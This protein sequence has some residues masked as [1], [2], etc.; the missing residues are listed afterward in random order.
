MTP[1]S[2]AVS[3]F[4]VVVLLATPGSGAVRPDD[5]LY[6]ASCVSSCFERAGQ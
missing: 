1:G 6:A 5:A 4:E 3:P 2:G